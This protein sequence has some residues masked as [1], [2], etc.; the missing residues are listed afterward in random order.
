[1]MQEE[2]MGASP[3]EWSERV[4]P[5]GPPGQIP[6]MGTQHSLQQGAQ[7]YPVLVEFKTRSFGGNRFIGQCAV[8]FH[9]EGFRVFGKRFLNS[10][11]RGLI[12]GI[13]LIGFPVAFSFITLWLI[14]LG[15][16]VVP[17]FVYYV[18][19]KEDEDF[20]PYAN[21]IKIKRK[22]YRINILARNAKGKKVWYCMKY[23][24]Y[25]A[26]FMDWV[27]Y[28]YLSPYIDQLPVV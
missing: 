1:M 5:P 3:P 7:I 8:T 2:H 16:L 12:A 26:P 20:V 11:V 27:A 28:T 17:T 6:K 18:C 14:P 21:I 10:G 9:A 22:G 15:I 19:R 25:N 23:H 13:S 4:Y 24:P